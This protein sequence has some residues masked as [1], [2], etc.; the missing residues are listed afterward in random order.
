[1]VKVTCN[2]CGMKFA[3][4]KPKH[5][6]L[7]KE[8]DIALKY[9]QCP[10]C[11][12]QFPERIQTNEQLAKVRM[13]RAMQQKANRLKGDA[14]EEAITAADLFQLEIILEQEK[15]KVEHGQGLGFLKRQCPR[16]GLPVTSL[17]AGKL[18]IGEHEDKKIYRARL[19]CLCGWTGSYSDLH[20]KS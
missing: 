7:D 5:R 13:L 3:L 4:G 19:L 14:R 6:W 15:L 11:K 10:K 12:R 18:C 16:C 8:N 1:M 9:Q 17:K 2:E 20:K